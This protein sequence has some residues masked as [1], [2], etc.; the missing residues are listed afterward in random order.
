MELKSAI[1]YMNTKSL[2]L[3]VSALGFLL[4]STGLRASVIFDTDPDTSG[5]NPANSTQWSAQ[6]F[7]MGASDDTLASVVL[8]LF[9]NNGSGGTFA[10]SLYDAAGANNTPGILLAD[11]IGNTSPADPGFY[12]YEPSGLSEPVILHA[13][14]PY[15][16][17]ASVVDGN[18]NYN[19]L[20]GPVTDITGTAL[21]L[22][23]YSGGEWSEPFADYAFDLQVNGITSVPELAI[24]SSGGLIT[25]RWPQSG[26]NFVLEACSSLAPTPTWQS[27]TNAVA[28]DNKG[29][30]VTLQPKEAAQ[31]FQLR[32]PNP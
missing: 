28:T 25:L 18:A 24:S 11:L 21:G 2:F 31:F 9:G 22:S 29:F 23:V 30:A 15:Y 32:L 10:V 6:G 14:M 26:S 13:N 8:H 20:D 27:V 5:S 7:I 4:Y 1:V 12:T 19:W 3:C 16:V 17:V